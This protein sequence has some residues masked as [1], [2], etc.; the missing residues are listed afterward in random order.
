MRTG[1]FSII[2]ALLAICSGAFAQQNPNTIAPPDAKKLD[3]VVFAKVGT[4]DLHMD[5]VM[6]PD[7]LA[8]PHP[9]VVWI[10]GGGWSK[11]T[12]K[13]NRAAWLAGK[14]YVGVSAE[15]RLSGEAI[16]P[17]QITDCKAAVRY[18]RARAKDYGID[19]NRIGVWGGSAG[20]HLVALLGT[21]G[22]VKEL[23]GNEG[24]AK[25]SSRVQAVCDFYG[26]TALTPDWIPLPA[27]DVTPLLGGTPQNKLEL[28]KLASPVRFVDRKDPPFLIVHGEI[29]SIVPIAH[30]VN[31]YDT[32]KKAGVDV[33][34][35]RVKNADHGFKGTGISPTI[36]EINAKVLAF[37][38]KQLHK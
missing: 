31:F 38:D 30:S 26:P 12:Y 27:P 36:E 9:C 18:L 15:Y 33:T 13:Q 16:Y 22:G 4:R 6:P 19:P 34:F 7:T 37:F 28:A 25:E 10:H 24:N 5:I 32:L 8:K 23:E 35:I 29:D 21:T 20:G 3:D 17:A 1:R 2:L 14:G 11:G